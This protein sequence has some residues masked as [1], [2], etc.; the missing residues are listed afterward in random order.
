MRDEVYAI[1]AQ[2]EPF[3]LYGALSTALPEIHGAGLGLAQ[4]GRFLV[5]RGKDAPRLPVEVRVNG[6][7]VRLTF[8]DRVPLR[9]AP[10]LLSPIVVVK[11]TG[12]GSSSPDFAARVGTEL[13]RQLAAI[14]PSAKAT[15]GT[16]RPTVRVHG[17][18]VVGV[19]VTV[20]CRPD[21]SIAIQAAGLGGK[22]SMGCGVFFPEGWQWP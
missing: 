1:T 15:V 13:D 16:G 5:V 19:P 17:R 6:R 20:D 21:D 4:R 3:A 10:R 18:H 12:C 14:A 7:A 9:P 8:V 22:R 2:V 11:T